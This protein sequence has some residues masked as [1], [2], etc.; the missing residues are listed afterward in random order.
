MNSLAGSRWNLFRIRWALWCRAPSSTTRGRPWLCRRLS[1]S[2]AMATYTG[3][4]RREADW[5]ARPAR[6]SRFISLS[7]CSF[8]PSITKTQS[9]HDLVYACVH[10]GTASSAFLP[11][12]ESLKS[13]Y[14]PEFERIVPIVTNV[15]FVRWLH[16]TRIIRPLTTADR[17]V[18]HWWTVVLQNWSPTSAYVLQ[19]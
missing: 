10:T 5:T 7:M 16:E 2:V 13:L 1:C 8:N 3:R 4:R 17:L 14:H 6:W 9:I 19:T 11:T 15:R 18:F 12:D